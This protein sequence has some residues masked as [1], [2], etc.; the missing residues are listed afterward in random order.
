M[1]H[2]KDTNNS[3]YALSDADI[4]NGGISLLPP[5]C[6][7]ISDAEA[8]AVRS[9]SI[10]IDSIRDRAID[11][12]RQQRAPILNALAGIGFDAIDANDTATQ[13]G[14]AQARAD[15]K[16]IT[17]LPALLDATNYDDMK[18]AVMARYREIADVAP[19]TVQTAFR[20]IFP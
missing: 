17:S 6:V 11:E 14:V 4:A 16:A 10:S 18:A 13:A 12:I 2:F 8:E 19:A 3:L 15:L 5:G 20:E 9:A 7:Q 1:N